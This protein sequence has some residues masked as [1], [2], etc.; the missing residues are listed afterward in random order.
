MRRMEDEFS[1]AVL[2]S[3]AAWIEHRKALKK[4]KRLAEQA[5]DASALAF[6]LAAEELRRKAVADLYYFGVESPQARYIQRL[7]KLEDPEIEAEK[8]ALFYETYN[9]D[10]KRYEELAT[11]GFFDLPK[12]KGELLRNGPSLNF[13]EEL[14]STLAASQYATYNTAR[15]NMR[16]AEEESW[17]AG[18]GYYSPAVC[19]AF[20]QTID[21]APAVFAGVIQKKWHGEARIRDR[22]LASL[23][24]WVGARMK[25]APGWELTKVLREEAK[26]TPFAQW[27]VLKQLIAE[28]PGAVTIEWAALSREEPAAVL[29]RRIEAKLKKQGL[30]A[31]KLYRKDRLIGEPLESPAAG[32]EDDLEEFEV[33]ETV[34]Q[35]LNA[36]PG[37]V[38][39]AKLSEQERRVYELDMR[40]DHNTQV[41][42]SELQLDQDTVRQYRKRYRDK[43][44]AA[45]GL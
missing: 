22:A 38:E 4:L 32:N 40:T 19:E 37:W 6:E 2:T 31:A 20:L 1:N 10:R 16:L 11:R 43:L 33:R 36:L 13:D 27:A 12:G 24:G 34:R 41:I 5:P 21:E 23:A 30:Q 7:E 28:L 42:A 17:V 9:H 3:R 44:R 26:D 14:G 45:A 8:E 35:Q 18:N 15:M 25:L 39:K 29:V